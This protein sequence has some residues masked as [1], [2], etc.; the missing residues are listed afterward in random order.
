VDTWY[1]DGV[2][3]EEL[4]GQRPPWELGESGTAWVSL[5][6]GELLVSGRYDLEILVQG[7]LVATA[8]TFV[9]REAIGPSVSPISFAQGVSA[10]DQPIDPASAFPQ[11]TFE[12]YAFFDYEGAAVVSEY[13]WVW[14]HLDSESVVESDRY[15]WEGGD[16]GNWWVGVERDEP[17]P[18]G[19]YELEIYFDD[20]LMQTGS[21]TVSG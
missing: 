8:T 13:R 9:G 3:D 21:F 15:P 18:A 17:L 7:E 12:V 20:Q 6:M 19:S 11:G 14:H 5:D 4:S 10:D 16:S 1:V 2:L